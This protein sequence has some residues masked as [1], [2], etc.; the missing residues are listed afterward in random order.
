MSRRRADRLAFPVVVLL[1]LV[2]LPSFMFVAP[3]TTK[4]Q[5]NETT[6][7]ALVVCETCEY[8][9]IEAALADAPAGSTI[10]VRGGDYAGPLVIN[11]S[12]H[13][14]GIDAPVIDG[15]DQGTV[16][17]IEAS[18]VTIEGF[19]IQNSGRNFDKEDSAV[20]VEGE[21]VS[22]L[23][24]QMLDALFGVN[25]ALAHDLLIEGNTIV[26]QDVEMGI[27]GDGIKVWYSHRTR[28]ISNTIR[29]SRD[30]LV[31]YSD[32]VEIRENTVHS[33]R[34]GFH[35]MNSNN[36]IAEHNRLYDN[37]VGIYLMYGKGFIIRDNLL[38]GSRGPSGHGIG[39][40][41]IDQVEVEGNIIYD[42]RIGAFID[43]SPLSPLVTNTFRRNLFS[44]NDIGIGLLPST[45]DTLFSENSFVDNQE[46]VSVL[47]GGSTGEIQWSENGRGNFWSDYAGYDADGDG[48]G[49]IAFRS[50]R[51]SEQ[52]MSSWP[53]LRLFRFSPAEAAVDFGAKAVPMF[54][55]DPVVID[56]YPLV[57]QVFPANAA[58]PA[59]VP[60]RTSAQVQAIGMLAVVFAVFMWAWRGSRFPTSI[61]R[62]GE[63]HAKRGE[64]PPGSEPPVSMTEGRP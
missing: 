25:A 50:E 45:H 9:S 35:F 55:Q 51:L 56:E 17:R 32:D 61:R 3:V 37:S 29:Q 23:D 24:N 10:K 14:I 18:D 21:R 49:D 11:Q 44:Y 34:Y 4:A 12:V 53:I 8:V 31:W 46:Q 5:S 48:I 15:H 59:H 20:Y 39:L 38:Q 62:N 54:R 1:L 42:N 58:L 7:G 41:E 43:N 30:L 64:R 40:K 2:T 27:R 26:G 6:P 60:D 33:G 47:G 57:E 52:L 28:I 13:L 63:P 16:V 36:G 19:T 22:I